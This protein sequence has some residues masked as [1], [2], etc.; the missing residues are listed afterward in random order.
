MAKDNKSRSWFSAERLRAHGFILAL[1]L[2]SLYAWNA[3]APGLLDRGGNLKGTDFLH[4]YALGSIALE[5]RGVDLYDT[6]AQAELAEAKVPAAAGIRYVP[7]YPPQVSIFFA[8]LAK[9]PYVPMLVLWLTASALL[10]G[11]C[12]YSIW[13][14]CPSLREQK[15]AVILFTIA[16]PAFF[17]LILWGQ[18]SVIALT[19][20]TLAYFALRRD[21][22]FLAGLALGSLMFKPQ[23][24]LGAGVVFC[25]TRRWRLVL[26][27]ALAA[28]VQ[29]FGAW[30]YY[31]W[32]PLRDWIQTITAVFDTLSVLEPKLY[33]TH[34][35]RTFWN[36]LLIPPRISLGLYAIS[37]LLVLA[38]TIA[39]WRSPL[40]L[41]IRYS[42][43]L[44]ATVLVSPHLIVYDMVILA[45]AFLMLADWL[46]ARPS[47]S[48]QARAA[49]ILYLVYLCPLMGPL[50]QWTHIQISVP[51][52]AALILMIWRLTR[53]TA[54]DPAAYSTSMLQSGERLAARRSEARTLLAE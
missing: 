19:C 32:G 8:P 49:G 10:Y 30:L 44:L 28:F 11:V 7:M 9:F 29:L 35:L 37:A 18:T 14:I 26:G 53:Q 5:H 52:M 3:S 6:D 17:H 16:F 45:P 36:L 50:S 25:A 51:C 15:L 21:K 24:G 31:G 1:T 34:S 40:P 12:A 41:S 4:L 22:E 43:L 33:Q 13:R 23:L 38:L 46:V 47:D 48:F 2:W 54:K 42:V 39:T 20:L 27:A